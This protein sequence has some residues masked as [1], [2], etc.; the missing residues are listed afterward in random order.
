[1]Y[2]WR[3]QARSSTDKIGIERALGKDQRG[4][5]TSVTDESQALDSGKSPVIILSPNSLS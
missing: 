1:M 5:D 2:D 3:G 4:T